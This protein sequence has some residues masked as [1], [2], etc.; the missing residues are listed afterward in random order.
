MAG[1]GCASE[2]DG[3]LQCVRNRVADGDA[4]NSTVSQKQT[5]ALQHM[6]QAR[7]LIQCL[8]TTTGVGAEGKEGVSDVTYVF[9]INGFI[10][11]FHANYLD[12]N[13]TSWNSRGA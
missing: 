4:V 12:I 5:G 10:E 6:I 8:A 11:M 9:Q 1:Q 13:K 7:P 2:E 3:T